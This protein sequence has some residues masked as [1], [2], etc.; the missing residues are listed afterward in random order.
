MTARVV[1]GHNTKKTQQILASLAALRAAV[2]PNRVIT[3][4]YFINGPEKHLYGWANV[5]Q[6]SIGWR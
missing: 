1:V 2:W 6:V 5:G 4:I 3:C